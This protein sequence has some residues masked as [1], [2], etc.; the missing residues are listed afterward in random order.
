[1]PLAVEYDRLGG[2]EVLHLSQVQDA[3]PAPGEMVVRVAAVG[4]NPFDFKVR[5][6]FAPSDAPFPRRLGSDF[7]GTVVGVGA[8]ARFGEDLPYAAGNPIQVGDTVLG[9]TTGALAEMVTVPADQVAPKPAGLSSQVAGSLATPGLTAIAALDL[10]DIGAEDTVLV[11][12]AAGGVGLI[13]SQLAVSRGAR[14]IGTASTKHHDLL[15]RLGVEPVTYGVGL[16]DRVRAMTDRPTAVQDNFGRETIDAALELGVPA[17]RIC[18]I[19]DHAAAAEL[20]LASPG[21]YRRSAATLARLA[22]SVANGDLYLPIQAQYPLDEVV[23]AFQHLESRHLGGKI[24][25]VP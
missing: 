4:I 1:M 5:T 22:D 24:V 14:V 10:L 23:Q 13:Y 17:P 15:R 9:W 20:G 16:V 7:T 19:V 12:A 11:S 25:V 2:P 3:V 18:T 6:G 21:R 8:E